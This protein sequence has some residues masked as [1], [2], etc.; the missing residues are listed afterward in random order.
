[1]KV[2]ADSAIPFLKGVLE[3]Y[4]EVVYLGGDAITRRDLA[5]ADILLTRTRTRCEAALLDGTPVKLIATATIG[6]DHIDLPYCHAHG[7][8]VTSAAG[9]NS[10][11]VADY[12]VSAI[13]FLCRDGCDYAKPMAARGHV[14][15]PNSER[16]EVGDE[17]SEG[18]AWLHPSRKILTIGI[19]GVGHVGSEV[20]R[21]CRAAGWNV[22]CCDPPRAEKEREFG[23]CSLEYL[24]ANSDVV[25]L[26]VPLDDSTRGMADEGFFGKMREGAMFVNASRGEVVDEGA[27][28]RA[29]G[30]L[31][32]IVIDTWCR[33]PDIDRE[34][35]EVAAIATP[36]IAGYSVQGKM[37]GTA[38]VVRAAAR[39]IGIPELEAFR[40]EGWREPE[41]VL[42]SEIP[43]KYPIFADDAMLRGAPER[44]ESLRTA[45][46]LRDEFYI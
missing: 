38:A 6:T 7:I 28:K 17:R 37:N 36:H 1:M 21:L 22:L 16:S 34:L 25:T 31:G 35:L 20:E 24:L 45:Y 33:E 39:F 40:P 41:K 42:L 10:L 26:H 44:F 4:A 18:L 11:A 27:L 30:R 46:K 23:F 19:V 9:C 8:T 12:V 13:S 2:V 14:N 5:D 29:V 3:P 43:E 15:G 32:A